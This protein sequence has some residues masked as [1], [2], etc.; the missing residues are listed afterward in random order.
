MTLEDIQIQ[1]E[2]LCIPSSEMFFIAKE[3]SGEVGVP[4]E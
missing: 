1:L 3:D 2:S 4:G